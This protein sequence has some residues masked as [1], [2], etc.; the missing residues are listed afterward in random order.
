MK[1]ELTKN[2]LSDYFNYS[3]SAFADNKAY[4]IIKGESLTFK[5]FGERVKN[6]VRTFD[7]NGFKEGE[8]I[9]LLGGSLC[10]NKNIFITTLPQ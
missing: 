1:K 3:I 5:E 7:E 9:A 10:H 6:L 4:S 2:T 8:K